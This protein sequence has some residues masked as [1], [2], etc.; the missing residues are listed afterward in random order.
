MNKT[1]FFRIFI[2]IGF[3][4]GCLYSYLNLQNEITDLRIQIPQLV[5]ELRKIK[6]ENTHLH[7][8]IERFECPENLMKLAQSKQFAHLRFPTMSQIVTLHQEN[9]YLD[10]VKEPSKD[11]SRQQSIRFA[12]GGHP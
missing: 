7:Y 10:Q 3:L 2:C 4:G 9:L 11:I 6:E 1:L 5:S 12:S 8:E